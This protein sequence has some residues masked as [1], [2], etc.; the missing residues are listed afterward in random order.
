MKKPSPQKARKEDVQR[1][2]TLAYCKKPRR[3][4]WA[5]MIA[6]HWREYVKAEEAKSTRE[7]MEQGVF[8]D[9]KLISDLKR[10]PYMPALIH[11]VVDCVRGGNADKLH[12]FADYLTGKG[13]A[14]A[15]KKHGERLRPED[16]VRLW[17]AEKHAPN[18]K[19]IV[20]SYEHKDLLDD[21][22][23]HGFN[24]DERQLRRLMKELGFSFK[25]SRSR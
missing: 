14:D 3:N 5:W 11:L 2:V 25:H 4:F 15:T 8:C 18:E 20:P 22:E 13:L 12:A 1:A 10:N 17:L 7:K 21:A 9:R 23:A 16:A 6:G 24:I 19:G